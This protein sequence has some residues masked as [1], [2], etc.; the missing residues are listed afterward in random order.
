[1]TGIKSHNPYIRIELNEPTATENRTML[2]PT[3]IQ[4][5]GGG[6]VCLHEPTEMAKALDDGNFTFHFGLSGVAMI[7][8]CLNGCLNT[9]SHFH[10]PDYEDSVAVDKRP[11]L[12]V[13]DQMEGS[14]QY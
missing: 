1:M 6:G 2:L 9:R 8:F 4:V 3:Y 10:I 12:T 5:L 11:K 14:F 13:T 7:V